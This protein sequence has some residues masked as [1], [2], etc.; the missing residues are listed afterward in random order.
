MKFS[1][2]LLLIISCINLTAQ[3]SS[4]PL[5]PMS[6]LAKYSAEWNKP[7]YAICNT[8]AKTTYMSKTEK[9]VIYILNLV[10]SY[11]QQFAST[12]LKNYPHYA[13]SLYY[14]SLMDTLQKLNPV[15]LLI[16][17]KNCYESAECHAS[18]SGSKGYVGHDRQT[19]ECKKARSYNGECC[20][21]GR[22]NALEIVVELLIDEDVPSLGHRSIC[23]SN[24]KGVGVSIQP[25]TRYGENAVL[26]FVY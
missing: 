8:A 12:V 22:S 15:N 2:V 11:P 18:S 7:I 5:V 19:D 20:D 9:E 13:N 21:Y 26:D 1:F 14:Q 23:L 17:N 4:K 6:P 25:H 10:R 16:P 24:Y 3:T